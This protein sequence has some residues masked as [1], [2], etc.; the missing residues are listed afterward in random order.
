MKATILETQGMLPSR[1]LRIWRVRP[2]TSTQGRSVRWRCCTLKELLHPWNKLIR[3]ESALRRNRLSRINRR[4]RRLSRDRR[5]GR[6]WRR[7]CWILCR[8]QNIFV[9]KNS[10]RFFAPG[11]KPLTNDGQNLRGLFL[12]FKS[13]LFNSFKTS[14]KLIKSRYIL[15]YIEWEN[16]DRE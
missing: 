2:S 8:F 6:R 13:L 9:L 4:L 3:T 1:I 11:W 15:R 12:K 5:W 7:R 10:F 14:Q 16:I